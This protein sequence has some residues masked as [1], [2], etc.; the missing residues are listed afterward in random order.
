M[1][2]MSIPKRV[3]QVRDDDR[4]ALERLVRSRTTEQRLIERARIVLAS[5]KGASNRTICEEV[6]VSHPTVTRWLNRYE[7]EGLP[8]LLRDRPRAGR[9]KRITQDAVAEVIRLTQEGPPPELGTHWST[10]TLAPLVGLHSVTVHRIW[11]AHGLQP[12]RVRTFKLSKDPQFVEKLHDVVG[13]YLNPPERAVVFSVDAKTQIQALDRTQPGLPL[14]KGR[15]GTMTHDY[16]RHGTT[17]LF[18]ALNVAS[19]EIFADCSAR[20]RHQEFLRF[21]R[22]VVAQVEPEL[23]VHFILDN[24]SVHKTEEVR[25]WLSKNPRVQFHFTPTSA[26][27][28]NLIERFFGELTQRQIRR[29]AVSSVKELEAAIETYIRTRNQNPRPFVWTASVQQILDK[30]ARAKQ[31][32]AALH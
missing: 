14:K 15:A 8:G 7:E 23:E 22:K 21:A 12:H 16:K 18:A 1:Y 17:T 30:V 5:A 4:A 3:I 2:L 19:G 11:K 10:R 9:P 32:S 6:G 31:T 24:S 13:L 28:L 20:Q 27:W 29:L 25:K 26:S